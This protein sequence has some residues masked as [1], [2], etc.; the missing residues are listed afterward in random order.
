MAAQ[1]VRNLLADLANGVQRRAR[2]LKNHR[3]FFAAQLS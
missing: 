3:Q 2:I 1:H